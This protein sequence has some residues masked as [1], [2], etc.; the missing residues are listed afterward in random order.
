MERRIYIYVAPQNTF[1]LSYVVAKHINHTQRSTAKNHK[2]MKKENIQHLALSIS[3]YL[4]MPSLF[5][6]PPTLAL[7]TYMYV[8]KK[9]FIYVRIFFF[10]CRFHI[11]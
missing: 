6:P 3:L 7:S 11:Q 10:K 8:S 1:S 2:R 5:S 9:M 4:F